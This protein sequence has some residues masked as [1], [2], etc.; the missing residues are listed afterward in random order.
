MQ[1]DE[2]IQGKKPAMIEKLQVFVSR[3]LVNDIPVAYYMYDPDETFVI[4]YD[5]LGRQLV[6]KIELR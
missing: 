1:L 3:E 6:E 2:M 5:R 4:P